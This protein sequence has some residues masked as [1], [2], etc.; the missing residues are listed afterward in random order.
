MTLSS[1]THF[2]C[3]HKRQNTDFPKEPK[4]PSPTVSLQLYFH[5]GNACN[6]QEHV[7]SSP[8]L[9]TNMFS[10]ADLASQQLRKKGMNNP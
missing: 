2:Q 9:L 4:Q 8:L 7:T 6:F 1:V 5:V 10:N 3:K